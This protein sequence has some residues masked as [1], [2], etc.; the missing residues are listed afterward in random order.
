MSELQK[1]KIL[2]PKNPNKST[3]IVNGEASGIL[4]WNDIKYPQFYETYKNLL[5][6]FW[7][8]FEINMSDDIKQ[9][10][11]L[12]REVQEVFLKINTLLSTLDSVQPEILEHAASYISDRSIRSI[13]RVISFQE[14]IHNQSYSYILQSLESL[15]VQLKAFDFPRTDELLIERNNVI[16]ELYEEFRVNPSP[17]NLVKALIGAIALEGI[18][19]YAAFAFF[20]NL[21]RNQKM[22]KSSTMISYIHRDEMSHRHFVCQLVRAI[23]GENPGLDSDGEVSKFAYELIQKVTE[24]EIKWSEYI[25]KDIDGID[26]HEL[27]KYIQFQAN[28]NLRMLGLEDVYEAN[29]NDMPWIQAYSDEAFNQSNTD[30]FEQKSRQ[31]AKVDDDNGFD[32][33]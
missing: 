14:V 23:L 11:T 1:V 28:K 12:P 17:I 22:V 16:V 33:L 31:Y 32:D 10:K 18:N 29:E 21:A 19:F 4:N 9:W 5:A 6:N 3:R 26:L 7:T 30:F 8:P 25:L 24:Y 20:Y 15:N 27:S 13:I 2:D